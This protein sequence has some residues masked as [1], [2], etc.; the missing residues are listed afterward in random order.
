MKKLHIAAAAL[1][2]ASS[3]AVFAQGYNGSES[4]VIGGGAAGTVSSV[5]GD[6][7][8]G[9]GSV[10]DGAGNVVRG[11]VAVPG[12]VFQGRSTYQGTPYQTTPCTVIGGGAA[13][14]CNS[15]Q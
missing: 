13:G 15:A 4:S 6:V 12:Q 9:V 3:T 11:I 7:A 5:T 2:L 14:T 1:L 10:L 8:G